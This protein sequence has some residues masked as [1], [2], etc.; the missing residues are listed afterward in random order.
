M[1]T[2]IALEHDS[3]PS[4]LPLL[5]LPLEPL[6]LCV[7]AGASQQPAAERLPLL[8]RSEA[9]PANPRAVRR[10]RKATPD[11]ENVPPVPLFVN[12]GALPSA[13]RALADP[14]PA[15]SSG[16]GEFC[17]RR[18]RLC[19]D[20]CCLAPVFMATGRPNRAGLLTLR[21]GTST[22]CAHGCATIHTV[23]IDYTLLPCSPPPVQGASCRS[24]CIMACL[25]LAV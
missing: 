8:P 3:K 12:N 2:T 19:E 18:A 7:C 16:W 4:G 14:S 24:G 20:S 10:A 23:C 1:T 13:K 21:E 6:L 11:R 25:L 17:L 22:P 5:C 9:A 15:S